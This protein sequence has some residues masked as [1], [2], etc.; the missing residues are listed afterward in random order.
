MITGSDV[1][2]EV[3]GRTLIGDASF[4]VG[5]G[6]KAGLVGRNG[7][8]KSSLIAVLVGQPSP[9]VRWSGDVRVT[10]V[11][12]YL[13]Q[14]PAPGG[15]GLDPS[16]FSH[17]L[18]AR[19]LDVLDAELVA[20]RLDME[21]DP[22]PEH[23]G[24]FSDVEERYRALGGYEAESEL[25]RF[26]DG[27]GIPQDLLFED[28]DGLSGG[29]RRRIDLMRV[30]FQDPDVMVL[31][32]PTNHLDGPAKRWLMEQLARFRGTLL[33]VSHDLELLDRS[34]T[35]VLHLA[36]GQLVEYRGTYASYR[37]QLA[38]RLD[39][40]QRLAAREGREIA[41]L[42]TLA[43]SMRASTQR[44]ARVAKSLDRRVERLHRTRTVVQRGER[45]A[46]FRLP[47]PPRAGD[48][49]L[50]V[51][52]LGIAY[53]GNVVLRGVSMAL[54][55]GDR[56]V[57]VGRNG[58]GKSSFLRC[59]AGVQE[60]TTGAVALGHHVVRGYFAQEHEQ[61]DPDKTALANL[62]DA[63]I[64]ADADRR[65]LLGSFGLPGE[66]AVQPAGTLSGGERAK[67]ALAMLAAGGANLLVLDEP[68]NNLD[69]PSILAVG[70]MLS[71]WPGTIVAVSHD[72]AFV[73]ALAPTHA[74]VLPAERYGYWREEHLDQVEL[75]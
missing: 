51:A 41:R 39:H 2:V 36:H 42:S 10:G 61:V 45:A 62:D 19:G 23:I 55:R 1:M 8:G 16:G 38:E 69:P 66:L 63:V 67:L 46:R 3:A 9:Q 35:K 74:L 57:V 21:K 43:D 50:E 53:G 49:P 52:D 33:V 29:Q 54:R 64:A 59:L 13:P 70:E 7:A 22:S 14:V 44:R 28:V 26:A 24:R 18:S 60:P 11:A 20:A 68:T 34:I 75:R 6:D 37:A 17:V 47:A 30:L 71:R 15:L 72:R 25:A 4:T 27:L 5:P 32:E 58:A 48:V 31:D 65:A 56:A 73:E 12:G 40:Q